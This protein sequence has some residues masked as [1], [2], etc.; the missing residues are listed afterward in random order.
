MPTALNLLFPVEP[1]GALAP[2]AQRAQELLGRLLDRRALRGGAR[3]RAVPLRLVGGGREGAVRCQLVHSRGSPR[4]QKS[5]A[6]L[7]SH[8]NK[9][10]SNDLLFPTFLAPA[11]ILMNT[12]HFPQ[13]KGLV[14]QGS[15]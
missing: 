10:F 15:Y 5:V 11:A 14:D 8:S 9:I 2:L 6:H 3:V 7:N 12:E 1:G 4:E 13:K